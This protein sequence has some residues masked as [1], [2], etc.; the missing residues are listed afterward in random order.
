MEEQ[1]I[2]IGTRVKTNSDIGWNSEQS[3]EYGNRLGTIEKKTLR[4][5]LTVSNEYAVLLDGDDYQLIFMRDEFEIF[6]EFDELN[7]L[8]ELIDDDLAYELDRDEYFSIEHE[9]DENL[10]PVESLNNDEKTLLMMSANV[11]HVFRLRGNEIPKEEL[12]EI[13]GEEFKITKTSVKFTY[14]SKG[15][16][17]IWFY[18]KIKAKN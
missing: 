3:L 11:H 13:L 16:T 12:V 9:S 14:K 5:E 6:D 2:P 10:T 7:E 18:H 17:E 1:E 8:S 4:P 15:Q